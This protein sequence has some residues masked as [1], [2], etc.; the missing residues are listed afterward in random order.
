MID[1]AALGAAVVLRRRGGI[2]NEPI[3]RN[4]MTRAMK[5]MTGM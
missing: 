5:Q 3:D 2:G 4:G 1:A